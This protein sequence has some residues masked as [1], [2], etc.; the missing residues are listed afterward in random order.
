MTISIKKNVVP[1][2]WQYWNIRCVMC[3]N[4]WKT[5]FRFM[6]FSVLDIWTIWSVTKKDMQTPPP[7]RSGHLYIKDA[8]FAETN[9]IS[10][11]RFLV[12]ELLSPKRLQKMRKKNVVQKLP[13]LQERCGLIRQWLSS[14]WVFF[15]A[16]LS[17]RDIVDF[18]NGFVFTFFKGFYRPKKVK[19]NVNL[20]RC[21][22]YWSKFLY[23]WFFLCD[24]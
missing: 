15:C 13:N 2:K 18:S 16:T 19:N 11:I 23:A 10:C 14:S 6:R 3:W 24:S 1:Q 21:A 17:F 20:I 5:V 8:Q 7:L 9:E 12:F 4:V 22:M